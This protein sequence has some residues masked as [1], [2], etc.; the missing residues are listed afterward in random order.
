MDQQ[1]S[2]K[3]ECPC[4]NGEGVI[5][6]EG[7]TWGHPITIG[8]PACDGYG[9]QVIAQRSGDGCDDAAGSE[10]AQ[11]RRPPEG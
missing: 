4:C 2:T 8:C 11:V 1:M 10:V 3:E 6:D 9:F 5:S 7:F